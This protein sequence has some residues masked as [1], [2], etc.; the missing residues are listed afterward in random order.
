LGVYT[1]TTP[2]KIPDYTDLTKSLNPQSLIEGKWPVALHTS[3]VI[4]VVF[5]YTG[6]D[7]FESATASTDKLHSMAIRTPEMDRY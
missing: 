1:N 2:N 4:D 7:A 5:V 3:G 6:Y